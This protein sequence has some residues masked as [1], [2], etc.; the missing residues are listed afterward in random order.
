MFIASGVILSCAPRS[1]LWEDELAGIEKKIDTQV[2]SGPGSVSGAQPATDSPNSM[3]SRLSKL[4]NQSDQEQAKAIER[5]I[6]R[7]V[8]QQAAMTAQKNKTLDAQFSSIA[9]TANAPATR[10]EGDA[11]ILVADKSAATQ[12][13]DATDSASLA[14]ATRN[15][16]AT[17]SAPSAIAAPGTEGAGA[18]Q[19]GF[20]VERVWGLAELAATALE[21]NP[22]TRESWQRARAAA[23]REQKALA[24]YGPNIGVEAGGDYF[25][26]P[27]LAFG[28]G[29]NAP[30]DREFRFTPQVYASWLLLD[31]GRRDADTDRARAELASANM[32]HD[33]TIQRVVVEVQRA[34]FK[35]ESALGLRTAAE[36]DVVA[37]RSVLKATEA[38]LKLGLATRPDTLIAR[39]AFAQTLYKLEKRR[40]DVFVAEGDLR[41]RTGFPA[42]V[43]IPIDMAAESDLPPMLTMGID[44]IIDQALASRP[45]LASA[46]LDLRAREAEVRR[47]QAE[48]LPEVVTRGTAGYGLYNYEVTGFDIQGNGWGFDGQIFLGG[49]WLLYDNGARDAALFEAGANRAASAARLAQ[50]RLNAA[51]EVWRAYYTLQSD[52]AQYDAAKALLVSAIDTFDAV[53]RAYELGLSTLPELL[54]AEHDL[55]QA[56]SLRIETR[57]DLLCSSANLIY[58]SGA[59]PGSVTGER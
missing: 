53:K 1:N 6:E 49:K 31:F 30:P 10:A 23:A 40:A 38:K 24:A 22:A 19:T 32:S 9:S 33:R 37:A 48:Y 41:T 35:L 16:N 46:V 11:N 42:T 15:Q 34:Y 27:G 52:R 56:R 12:N 59:G 50:S 21:A 47:A 17:D 3:V 13:K 20:G 44:G 36:Q 28:Y 51:D 29:S 18:Q 45:D 55:F 25:Q 57:S 14:A 4:A 54:D 7:A 8:Q 58:A 2:A 26:E 43:A 5:G 39:Q